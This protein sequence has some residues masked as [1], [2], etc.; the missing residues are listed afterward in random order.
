MPR[1]MGRNDGA[2]TAG[3]LHWQPPLTSTVTEHHPNVPGARPGRA[4]VERQA[5]CRNKKCVHLCACVCTCEY[6]RVPQR[7]SP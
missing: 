5:T 2:W 4:G 7:P 6:M 3:C 1:T